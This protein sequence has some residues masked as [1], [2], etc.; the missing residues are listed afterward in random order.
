MNTL[1]IRRYG[2]LEQ[3]NETVDKIAN[4]QRA[5]MENGLFRPVLIFPEGGNTNGLWMGRFKR[6][7][8]TSLLPAVPTVVKYNWT[9]FSP[10][11][12][13]MAFLPFAILLLS[14]TGCSVEL[15]TMP[16]FVPNEYLFKTH[17]DK[18]KGNPNPEKWE[19]YAWATRDAL[20]KAGNMG[21][22]DDQTQ[23]MRLEYKAL[24][25]NKLAA[26]IV[27]KSE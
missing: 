16:T 8:F 9:Y 25:G 1:F 3:R 23:A 2:S 24:L 10:T 22:C 15:T 5:V 21:L 17:A 12:E 4:R 14:S 27:N 20:S 19:I 11:Y 26:K 13:N 6:G 7:T 18:I